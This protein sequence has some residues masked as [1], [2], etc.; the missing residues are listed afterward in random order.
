[1]CPICRATR[2]YTLNSNG[3]VRMKPG[4]PQFWSHLG[5]AASHP[6]LSPTHKQDEEQ[7]QDS[8]VGTPVWNVVIP[9][10]V[11][12]TRP[13]AH[14]TWLMFAILPSCVVFL[15]LSFTWH[16]TYLILIAEYL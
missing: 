11:T 10:S 13:S 8:K 9:S 4:G 5:V 1:M 15:S 16:H 14:P 2:P 6:L 7:S 12:T 3:W